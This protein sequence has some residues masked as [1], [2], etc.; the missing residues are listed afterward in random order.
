MIFGSNIPHLSRLLLPTP[1]PKLSHRDSMPIQML[2]FS[3]TFEGWTCYLYF[4]ALY[5]VSRCPS[6]QI[7]WQNYWYMGP[8][9]DQL[10]STLDLILIAA[11]PGLTLTVTVAVLIQWISYCKKKPKKNASRSW[12]V[13]VEILFTG[14]TLTYY[15]LFFILLFITTNI[16]QNDTI[17]NCNNI[18]RTV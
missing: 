3:H 18:I 12:Y 9:C 14:L 15:K 7:S 10:W 17:L 11:V 13:S 16:I 8:K 2:G 4:S 1:T 6:Y 5:S